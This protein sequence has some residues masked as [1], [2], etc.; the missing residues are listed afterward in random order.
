MAFSDHEQTFVTDGLYLF[1]VR[2][3]VDSRYIMAL[4]NSALFVFLYRLLVLEEDRVLAQVKPT[5]IEDMPIRTINPAVHSDLAA[6]DRLVELVAQLEALY[7]T[8]RDVKSRHERTTL[9]RQI[10]HN[11]SEIDTIVFELYS[12]SAND[13][14]LVQ[15]NPLSLDVAAIHS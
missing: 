8:L 7:E 9:E 11:R 14:S 3:G 10:G 2:E 12:L 15:G 1:G 5:L 13:L 4:L 6:H